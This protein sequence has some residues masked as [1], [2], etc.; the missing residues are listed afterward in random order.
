MNRAPRRL[1]QSLLLHAFL[2]VEV[3]LVRLRRDR[4]TNRIGV[5]VGLRVV[6]VGVARGKE[7]N[8]FLCVVSLL[9]QK[10]GNAFPLPL[11]F[12]FNF[13]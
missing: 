5:K 4:L 13:L 2:L 8:F 9:T 10:Q 6:G 3:T 1:S 12:F 7:N 11:D